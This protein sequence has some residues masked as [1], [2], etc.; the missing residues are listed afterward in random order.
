MDVTMLVFTG[1]RERS[2]A[3]Y[4]GL[5]ERAGFRLTRVMPTDSPHRI[6]EGVAA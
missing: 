5:F 3:Q 1:G 2:A 6:V 4:R